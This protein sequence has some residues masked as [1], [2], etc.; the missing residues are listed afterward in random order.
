MSTPGPSPCPLGC[1][2]YSTFGCLGRCDSVRQSLIGPIHSSVE[3]Q[4]CVCPK[5]VS[6]TEIDCPIR[7]SG[8]QCSVI[9]VIVSVVVSVSNGLASEDAIG[10]SFKNGLLTVLE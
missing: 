3:V 4:D 8:I 6:V 5:C 10:V 7:L 2:D 1:Y 9:I